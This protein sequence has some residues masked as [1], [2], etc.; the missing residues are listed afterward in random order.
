L[1]L[2]NI[3]FQVKNYSITKTDTGELIN[4][5]G[6]YTL[7]NFLDMVNLSLG[8]GNDTISHLEAFYTL[9]AYHTS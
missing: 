5:G 4:L 2:N 8:L 3:G 1:A 9:Y 6:E 7:K